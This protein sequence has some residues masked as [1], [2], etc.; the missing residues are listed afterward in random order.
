M[1]TTDVRELTTEAEFRAAFPVLS[2]LRDHLSEAE[3]LDYLAEM[4]AEGYRLFALFD[5]DEIVSVAGVVVTTN[6]Y[7][8]R[9]LFVYDLVTRADRRSE[10]FGTRL[11]TFVEEWARDHD[12]ES[13]TLESGLWREDAHRFYEDDLDMD[14]YCYTFKKE[15]DE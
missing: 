2:Q 7:N 12:C 1:S 15:L 5:D 14:R 4:R 11:M 13:L 10:G 6:F 9:H 8:G 3:Y